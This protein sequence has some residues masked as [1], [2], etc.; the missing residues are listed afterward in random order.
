MAEVFSLPNMSDSIFSFIAERTCTLFFYFSRASGYATDQRPELRSFIPDSEQGLYHTYLQHVLR[1]LKNLI[2]D[3]MSDI[4]AVNIILHNA[5]GVNTEPTRLEIRQVDTGLRKFMLV[6]EL[7]QGHMLYVPVMFSVPALPQVTFAA[8][9]CHWMLASIMRQIN[10]GA[11]IDTASL[12]RLAQQKEMIFDWIQR[13]L[14][15]R[16]RPCASLIGYVQ[17]K[18]VRHPINS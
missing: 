5:V 15:D 2:L 10:H 17:M 8:A 3:Q 4:G 7:I 14:E 9:A 13:P 6:E 18:R 11:M 1:L 16:Y 12:I